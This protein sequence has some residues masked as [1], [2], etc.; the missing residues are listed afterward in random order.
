MGQELPEGSSFS[1]RKERRNMKRIIWWTAAVLLAVIVLCGT[2][3]CGVC[4]EA[5]QSQ[6]AAP[7]EPVLS[8]RVLHTEEWEQNRKNANRFFRE[9]DRTEE[10]RAPH[11]FWSGEKF[12]LQAVFEG[13]NPPESVFVRI[14]GTEYKTRLFPSEGIYTG[15]L[16]NEE[17][18]YRWGQDGPEELVFLFEAECGK[19]SSA[20]K[21]Q[22]LSCVCSVT[23]DDRQPYWMLHRKI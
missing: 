13:E 19:E 8:G 12:V 5:A 14:K 1:I 15:V 21:R 10:L 3:T 22:K 16:F 20:E 6:K 4:A 18:M 7:S 2:L 9:H 17:M 11:V 23:A